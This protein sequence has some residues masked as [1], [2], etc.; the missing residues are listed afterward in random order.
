MHGGQ[1]PYC[2]FSKDSRVSSTAVDNAAVEILLRLV[3]LP[4]MLTQF[5]DQQLTHDLI[6]KEQSCLLAAV[7]EHTVSSR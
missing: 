1:E 5:A 4:C 7:F 2:M 3:S 6:R